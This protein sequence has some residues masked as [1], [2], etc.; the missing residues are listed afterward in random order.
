M[1]KEDMQKSMADYK[2]WMDAHKD[3]FV[4]AGGPLS[5]VKKVTKG[6]VEDIHNNIGAYSIV[7]AESIDAAAQM[8]IDSPHFEDDAWIEVMEMPPGWDQ[9]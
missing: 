1:P 4:D 6:K 2:A 5:K 7:Q 9:Q 8:F 3:I